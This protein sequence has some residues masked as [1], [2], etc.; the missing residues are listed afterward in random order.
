MVEGVDLSPDA[1]A[2]AKRLFDID[3]SVGQLSDVKLEPESFDYV[4]LSHVVEHFFNPI[5]ELRKVTQLLKPGGRVYIEVPNAQGYGANKSGIFWY[6]WDAPRH[7][8]TFSPNNLRLAAENSGLEV[9]KLATIFSDY[10][11]WAMT[12][13]HEDQTGEMLKTRPFVSNEQMNMWKKNRADA[14]AAYVN[15]PLSG[16]FISCWLFKPL[17]E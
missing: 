7:L 2:S 1:A 10:F 9:E 8:F 6:G 17:T 12:Y 4:H 14:S 5:E 13:E 3:V 15:D 16:D 11:P